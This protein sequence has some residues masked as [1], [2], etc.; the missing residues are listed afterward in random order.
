VAEC[1]HE[2]IELS[3][4]TIAK[5]A[6]AFGPLKG[7]VQ[8][9]D[10]ALTTPGGMVQLLL[11]IEVIEATF[12]GTEPRPDQ[13]IR[14]VQFTSK[15]AATIDRL[16]RSAPIDKLAGVEL[17]HFGA[18]LK[19]SWRANDWMWGRIDAAERLLQ[20]VDS[21]VGHRLSESGTLEAHTRAAQAAVLR[22]ELPT[23]LAEIESDVRL[24][25]RSCAEAKAFCAAVRTMVGTSAGP[26]DLSA[27]SQ[28]QV[29]ELL[30]LQLV[31]EEN[32]GMEV[33]SN[34]ATMTSIGALATTAGVLRAQG[35][36]ALR[37]PARLLG[38]S[39]SVAWRIVQ[40]RRGRRLRALE[41]LAAAMFL[42][43]LVGIGVDVFSDVDLGVWRYVSWAVLV[44]SPVLAVFAA[45]WLLVSVGRRA[46]GRQTPNK[47][48][49]H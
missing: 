33:G 35:P 27:L 31:G 49:P 8:L 17:A 18:F 25:A 39:S 47:Q 38:T 12:A 14:L 4:A 10:G 7:L 19:R 44:L 24:G 43:G 2:F 15:G 11:C 6:I 34:L 3:R 48:K 37:G 28:D 23:V 1:L 45:P 32:I 16:Q 9:H 41:W 22:Q 5:P 13:E 42:V 21:M 26:V 30:A 20:L 46:L 36:R 29:E 40:R